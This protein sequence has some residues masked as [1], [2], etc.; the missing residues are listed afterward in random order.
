[1]NII[2]SRFCDQAS[3]G[4]SVAAEP[5]IVKCSL[6]LELLNAV[7]IRNGSPAATG[8]TP[9]HIANADPIQLVVVVIGAGSVYINS[10]IRRRNLR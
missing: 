8:C 6:N 2:A 10:I 3:I 7:R 9:L 5:S 1:M 4:T